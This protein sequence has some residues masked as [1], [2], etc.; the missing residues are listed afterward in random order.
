MFE[1]GAAFLEMNEQA[2]A[3]MSENMS[4]GAIALAEEMAAELEDDE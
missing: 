1:Y 3:E 2:I 4:P